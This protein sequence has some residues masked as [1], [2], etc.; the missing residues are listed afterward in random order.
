MRRNLP[1]KWHLKVG[2]DAQSVFDTLSKSQKRTIFRHLRELLII[3]DP[4]S[5]SSVEML[6]DKIFE[7]TRKFRAGDFR[8]LF[9]ISPIE[10]THLKHKYKG[11]LY[12]LDI[13]KR[14]DA[15]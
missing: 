12:I 2:A 5:H 10:V 6:K 1:H 11:T 7:R 15:Y 13:R 4:Y 14:K 9:S 8:V 3:D